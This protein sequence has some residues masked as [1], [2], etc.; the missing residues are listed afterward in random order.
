MQIQRNVLLVIVL[1]LFGSWKWHD[2]QRSPWDNFKEGI[3]R[4]FKTTDDDFQKTSIIRSH[5]AQL[6][7]LPGSDKS[8]IDILYPDNRSFNLSRFVDIFQKDSAGAICGTTALILKRAYEDFGY[9][10]S[11]LSIGGVTTEFGHVVC[12]VKINQ[13]GKTI[14]VIQDAT[15]NFTVADK[16]GSPVDYTEM[17]ALLRDRKAQDLQIKEEEKYC[18]YLNEGKLKLHQKRDGVCGERII[19]VKSSTRKLKERVPKSLDFLWMSCGKSGIQC[20]DMIEQ[21]G[22]SRNML[23]FFLVDPV[24]FN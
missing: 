2:T 19:V 21:R 3:R 4:E 23:N 1:C 14:N 15:F 22:Y 18:D 10:C 16:Q 17:M 8:D 7:D 9:E 12:L 13:G 11:I 6:V 5:I 24:I 20:L